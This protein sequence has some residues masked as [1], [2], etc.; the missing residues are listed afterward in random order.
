MYINKI[1]QL[2]DKIIEDYFNTVILKGK[3]FHKVL[4]EN[5]FC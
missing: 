2:L 1:D 3:E 4:N 5:K